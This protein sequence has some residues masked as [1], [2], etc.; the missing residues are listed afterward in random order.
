MKPSEI[1][2]YRFNNNWIKEDPHYLDYE[3]AE[4]IRS[5]IVKELEEIEKNITTQPLSLKVNKATE[6]KVFPLIELKTPKNP[7]P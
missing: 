7:T 3:T 4:Y 6:P 2:K 5:E 1:I